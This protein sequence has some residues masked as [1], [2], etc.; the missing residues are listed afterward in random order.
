MIAIYSNHQK[1]NIEEFSY[2]FE[3]VDSISNTRDVHYSKVFS[4]RVLCLYCDSLL[5][6]PA[7][8]DADYYSFKKMEQVFTSLY[9]QNQTEAEVIR[10]HMSD[11][12]KA[13]FKTID[14]K[15]DELIESL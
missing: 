9:Y 1:F 6:F 13:N 7:G 8:K 10:Q 12:L 5:D 14:Q 15:I 11:C 4:S 2:S 3:I